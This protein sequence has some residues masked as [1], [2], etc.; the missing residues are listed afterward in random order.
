MN[1]IILAAGRGTRLGNHNNKPKCLFNIDGLSLIERNLVLF[2]EAGLHP[3]LVTG[4]Q[5]DK[6][7]FLN[8]QTINNPDFLETNMLWSLYKAT[9]YMNED[10]IICYSDILVNIK[11]VEQMKNFNKGIGLIVDKDWLRYWKMRFDDPLDDAESLKIS[12]KGN[13]ISIGQKV[14]NIAEIEGQYIGFI[15]VSGKQ[16]L[17]FKKI[18]VDYCEN[19]QT[20]SLA[21]KAY[22][23]DFLQYLIDKDLDIKEISTHGGWIEIDS[24]SDVDAAKKSGRLSIID[25]DIKRIMSKNI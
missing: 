24:P 12:K 14:N 8:L 10:F 4:Y 9:D 16:R 21:K 13:I 17:L 2:K 25:K 23:T 3:I 18:L 7:S 19:V 11:L 15:K 6:L 1:I 5:K 22:L 20:S